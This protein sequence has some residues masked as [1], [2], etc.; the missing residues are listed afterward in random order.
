MIEDPD[1]PL[2]VYRRPL[3]SSDATVCTTSKAVTLDAELDDVEARWCVAVAKAHLTQEHRS[4]IDVKRAAAVSLISDRD[5]RSTLRHCPRAL[6]AA[7][8]LSVPL[9][10]LFHRIRWLSPAERDAIGAPMPTG[11]PSQA[12]WRFYRVQVSASAE[13]AAHPRHAPLVAV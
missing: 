9:A 13:C 5:L 2:L 10:A 6:D 12:A 7:A 4:L 3:T 1:T 11:W 8:A